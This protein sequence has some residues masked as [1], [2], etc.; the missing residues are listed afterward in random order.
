[1][2]VW[3]KTKR[4]T[5]LR[6]EGDSS[7]ACAAGARRIRGARAAVARTATAASGTSRVAISTRIAAASTGGTAGFKIACASATAESACGRAPSRG[8]ARDSAQTSIR[9]GGP[10]RAVRRVIRAVAAEAAA[11]R[12]PSRVW[13]GSAASRRCACA[14]RSLSAGTG[15]VVSPASTGGDEQGSSR[16]DDVTGSATTGALVS[17]AAACACLTDD[18]LQHRPGRQ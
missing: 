13:N 3:E 2:A 1:V 18:N 7:I 10:A 4:A 16:G 8:N 15:G 6:E 9:E 12:A 17:A 14:E 11:A 5:L